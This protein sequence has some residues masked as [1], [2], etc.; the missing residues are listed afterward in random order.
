MRRP[1]RVSR[2]NIAGGP[3]LAAVL[4]LGGCGGSSLSTVQNA[5]GAAPSGTS[6]SDDAP[7]PAITQAEATGTAVD[8][9]IVTAAAPF[10]LGDGS[11][12]STQMMHQS[13]SYAYMQGPNFQALRLPYGQGRLSM[14]I[15]LPDAGVNLSSFAAGVTTQQLNSW[16]AQL[17]MTNGSIALPRFSSNYG[18]SLKSTLMSLGM[19][20]AFSEGANFS[21]FLPGAFV[22]DVE[23]KTV[24]EVDETGTVAAGAT[25]I[26]LTEELAA[27]SFTMTMDR[28]FMYAIQDTKTGELLFIGILVDPS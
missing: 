27:P 4:L 6:T 24:V 16:A 3:L 15:I 9:A 17:Q 26:G 20:I 21:A 5:P 25:T 28:P 10:T 13:G 8:P 14:L 7:P 22:S 19:G 11:Q 23:H 12:A 18:S 1:N 2:S